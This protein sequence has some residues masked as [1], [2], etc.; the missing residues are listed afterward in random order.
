MNTI[1]E[2]TIKNLNGVK[3]HYKTGGFVFVLD[4][5]KDPEFALRLE[6]LSELGINVSQLENYKK[7][8][9]EELGKGE[10]YRILK[11]LEQPSKKVEGKNLYIAILNKGGCEKTCEVPLCILSDHP[12][13]NNSIK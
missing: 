9:R 7:I 5:V 4:P 1:D 8:I 12:Y 3:I 10:P 13:L 11:I 6:K 2:I